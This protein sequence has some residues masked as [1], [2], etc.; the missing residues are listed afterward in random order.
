MLYYFFAA[1]AS[2]PASSSISNARQ[3]LALL[4]PSWLSLCFAL[5]FCFCFSFFSYLFRGAS[6]VSALS[7]SAG[8]QLPTCN[9]QLATCSSPSSASIMQHY[10]LLSSVRH[11][12][13]SAAVDVAS[14]LPLQ[15]QCQTLFLLFSPSSVSPLAVPLSVPL[16]RHKHINCICRFVVVF[17]NKIKIN[18]QVAYYL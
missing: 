7:S 11:C 5:V 16:T 13:C 3:L 9:G 1:P 14:P 18:D 12:C 4:L 2:A 8:Q 17:I 15:Y 6:I 10:L